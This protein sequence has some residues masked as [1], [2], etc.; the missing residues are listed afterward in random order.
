MRF[1]ELLIRSRRSRSEVAVISTVSERRPS[2]SG[3]AGMK[4]WLEYPGSIRKLLYIVR[5]ER[6]FM[7]RYGVLELRIAN[8]RIRRLGV[9]SPLS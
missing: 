5:A 7:P 1:D 3:L 9:N 2:G 4:R 6:V 8:P